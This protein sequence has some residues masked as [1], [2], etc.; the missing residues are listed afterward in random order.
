LSGWAEKAENTDRINSCLIIWKNHYA[1]HIS[2]RKKI[3]QA[4]Q[5]SMLIEGYKACRSQD[6]KTQA[7][8]LMEQYRVQVS[9]PRK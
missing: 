5:A 6:I 1:N 7:K 4:V 3:A 8:N 2:F 9:I